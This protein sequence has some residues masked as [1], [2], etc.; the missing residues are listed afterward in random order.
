MLV[1]LYFDKFVFELLF[2]DVDHL[3][4]VVKTRLPFDVVVVAVVLMT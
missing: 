4:D 2:V 3:I 1:Y